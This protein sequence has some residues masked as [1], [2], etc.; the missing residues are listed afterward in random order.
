[1]RCYLYQFIDIADSESNEC[2]INIVHMLV[3]S[4]AKH[5]DTFHDLS[6]MH[7]VFV[8]N[9]FFFSSTCMM[10]EKVSSVGESTYF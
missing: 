4:E 1:M 5:L 3:A 7:Q 6:D 2:S 10:D 8:Q 9:F